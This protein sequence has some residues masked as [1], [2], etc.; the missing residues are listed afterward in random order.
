MKRHVPGCNG[1]TRLDFYKTTQR[2]IYLEP[3]SE[4]K[5]KTLQG[6]ALEYF[7]IS[8]QSYVFPCFKSTHIKL[9]PCFAWSQDNHSQLWSRFSY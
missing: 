4:I 8:V 2:S 1:C 3:S 6:Y 9:H 5:R 7:H